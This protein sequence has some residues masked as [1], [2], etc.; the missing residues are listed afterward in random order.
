MLCKLDLCSALWGYGNIQISPSSQPHVL[1][2]PVWR[3][4]NSLK[5]GPFVGFGLNPSRAR[6]G[7]TC[8]GSGPPKATPWAPGKAATR[9]K[10]TEDL[11]SRSVQAID[12][13]MTSTHDQMRTKEGQLDQRSTRAYFVL[14]GHAAYLRDCDRSLR[15]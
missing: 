13:T 8:V 15:P 11:M 3:F 6:S 4:L 5:D 12:K 2:N 1:Y 14:Q 7:F 10:S 9:L